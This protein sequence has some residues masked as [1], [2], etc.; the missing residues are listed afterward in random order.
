MEQSRRSAAE[1]HL[2]ALGLRVRVL[3]TQRGLTQEQLGH[4]AGFGRTIVGYIER[5]ER[6]IGVSH[7]W[8]LVEA[9]GVTADELFQDT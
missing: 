6:D 9:L 3:R 2:R 4:A 5:A 1:A 7:V 8:P